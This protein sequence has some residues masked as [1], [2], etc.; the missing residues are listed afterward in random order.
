[1]SV[2]KGL[3]YAGGQP[4]RVAR[5]ENR[6]W[7]WLF[8]LGVL[9]RNA[10]RLEVRGR[11]S[12]RRITLPVAIVHHAGERYLVAMLGQE[13]QWVRNARA[14]SGAARL[15]H[16][17]SENVVLVEDFSDQRAAIL[18]AYLANRHGGQ[19][20]PRHPV[21]DARAHA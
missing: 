3:E 2:R 20:V 14:D 19:D 17:R 5:V 10:A 16:G 6:L 1:M 7:G 13:T 12:G 21:G 8:G 4:G 15:R 18:R 9:S 11:R